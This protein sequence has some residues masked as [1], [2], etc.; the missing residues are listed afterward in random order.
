MSESGRLRKGGRVHGGG[1][2]LAMFGTDFTMV[3]HSHNGGCGPAS[4]QADG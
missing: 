2:V 4:S 1:G 3:L